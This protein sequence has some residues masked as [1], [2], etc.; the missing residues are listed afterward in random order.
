MKTNFREK[1]YKLNG[2]NMLVDQLVEENIFYDGT[3]LGIEFFVIKFSINVG[4]I[5]F[6][7]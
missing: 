6:P 5:Y 3:V 7:S 2:N 4:V 1:I